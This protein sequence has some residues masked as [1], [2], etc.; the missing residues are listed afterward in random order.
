M[1]MKTPPASEPIASIHWHNTDMSAQP[2]IQRT[3]RR[4]AI[5]TVVLFAAM[6]WA[7]YRVLGL[8]VTLAVAGASF[9]LMTFRMFRLAFQVAWLRDDQQKLKAELDRVRRDFINFRQGSQEMM[10]VVLAE[11]YPY[12]FR[13]G[14]MVIRF[15]SGDKIGLVATEYMRYRCLNPDPTVGGMNVITGQAM[16]E[17]LQRNVGHQYEG[18]AETAKY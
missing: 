16:I 17:V 3:D 6:E 9:V 14:D 10:F 5:F 7:I 13:D 11:R 1:V 12:A 4:F 15:P 2:K 8:N 18:P